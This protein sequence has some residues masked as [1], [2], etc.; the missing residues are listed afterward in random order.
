MEKRAKEH[1]E[2]QDLNEKIAQERVKA[3][4]ASSSDKSD[5]EDKEDKEEVDDHP[6]TTN[7]QNSDFEKKTDD[8][9]GD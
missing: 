4:E 3:K 1:E 9:D 8:Q 5:K 7:T 6:E 2:F